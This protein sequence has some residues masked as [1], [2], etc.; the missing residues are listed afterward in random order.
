MGKEKEDLRIVYM[1]TPE[2][3]VES[4]RALV[5]N[6]YHV[7][8]VVTM[9]DKP[10]GRHMSELQASPVKK[11]ALSQ[12]I[13][14][15]QPEKLKDEIFL[16]DLRDLKADLQIV[17]AFRMLPEVVWNMPRLGTF[18][19]HASL[20]PQYRGAAPINWAVINGEKETGVTTFFLT[21]EI[22]TGKII[23]QK[24][25][26]VSDTDTA[27][28]I[29]DRLMTTGA[30]LVLETVDLILSA[31]IDAISQESLYVSPSELRPAPKIFKET[32]RI[33][34]TLPA[35]DIHNFVRGLSPYPAA[36]THLISMDGSSQVLKIYRTTYTVMSHS[37]S[38]GTLRLSG[39]N[40]L[41]VAT[42]DGFV[43]LHTVQIAGKKQM[44]VAD[45]LNGFKEIE[46]MYLG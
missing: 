18:N 45:F 24:R 27:G 4:L 44:S 8:G 28:E 12:A 25:V 42:K 33:D 26:S 40:S 22:D 41:D 15:L 36:W 7:V 38:V 2:F 23:L 30:G 34:W 37:L 20:L 10:V 19:L 46:T 14:V 5:E 31:K 3:A 11:Y 43:H 1:G 13:P 32:C 21:H 16:T 9:P 39:K 29:H 17:V 35:R 6:G